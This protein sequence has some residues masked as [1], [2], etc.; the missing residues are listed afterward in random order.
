V[1][2]D[3]QFKRDQALPAA[4]QVVYLLGSDRRVALSPAAVVG[5][6][7]AA[8]ARWVAELSIGRVQVGLS[9]T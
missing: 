2:S 8:P 1:S 5:E 6:A 3:L 4:L 9:V 7:E